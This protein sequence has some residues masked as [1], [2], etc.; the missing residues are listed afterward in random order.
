MIIRFTVG[1]APVEFR[2]NWLTGR[3]DLVVGDEAVALQ[4]PY[5]PATHFSLSLTRTWRHNVAGHDVV[6][7]KL[8]PLLLAGWRRQEYRVLVDGQVVAEAQG[9]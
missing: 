4:S 2:R 9:Y 7:E 5:N 3:A 1:N 8:R 6:I